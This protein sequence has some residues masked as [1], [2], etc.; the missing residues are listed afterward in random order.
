MSDYVPSSFQNS[1][2]LSP[3]LIEDLKTLTIT[4][5][6]IEFNVKITPLGEVN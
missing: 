4:L 3:S 1:L 5:D 2:L 6:D